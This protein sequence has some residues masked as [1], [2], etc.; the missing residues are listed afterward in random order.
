MLEP[1]EVASVLWRLEQATMSWQHIGEPHGRRLESDIEASEAEVRL[2]PTAVLRI[3]LDASCGAA[4][5]E[6]RWFREVTRT[7]EPEPPGM[8]LGL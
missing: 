4:E 1:F 7:V 6:T 3:A 8:Q 2:A 5:L